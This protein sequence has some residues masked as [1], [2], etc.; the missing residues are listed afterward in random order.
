MLAVVLVALLLLSGVVYAAQPKRES[1]PQLATLYGSFDLS[2]SEKV[3]AI[4]ELQAPSIVEAKH[5]GRRQTPAKL[6]NERN[7]VIRELRK[8]TEAVVLREYFQVFSGMAIKLPANAIPKLLAIPGVQAVYP[9]VVYTANPFEAISIEPE[10]YF[11]EMLDSAPWIGADEA[12]AAGLTGKGITVAIIDTG[13]DYTHPDLAHA[14]GAYKGWDFVDNDADPQEGPGQNHGTH[15]AGTVAANGLIRGVAPGV[16]LLAYR[17]LG[18]RGGTT[19]DVVAGIERAVLD[20]ANI[21]NLSLGNTLNSPDWATSIALDWAMAEGVVAVTSNGNSGPANWTVGSPAASR[22]AISV[23]ASQL[24]Y[25]VYQASIFTSEGV[26]YPSARVMGFND[27]WELLALHGNQFEMVDVG[28]GHPEDF[29]G[30]DLE[31]KIALI[32]RGGFPFFD[33]A[34]NAYRAGAVGA[35]IYNN[36]PGDLNFFIPGMVIPTIQLSYADGR[37]ILAE[38]AS[39]NNM[40]TFDI[41]L[42]FTMPETVANFS[43]RGPAAATWMI[44]PDVVAPGVDII[45]TV[46]GGYASFQGTSMASPHVAGAAAILLQANPGWTVEQVKSALMNT[47]EVLINPV[48]G[49][50]YPHNTQGAGSIRIPA[51]LATETLILPG[52]HSFGVFAKEEGT[53]SERQH[54]II[55]NLS[56]VRKRYTV[57]VQFAN[58]IRVNVSNNLNVGA[59]KSQQVNMNVRVEAGKMAPGYYEGVILVSDGSNTFRVPAILFVGEPDYPRITHGGIVREADLAIFW[60]F[61]PGGADYVEAWIFSDTPW[62]YVGY[63]TLGANL[64]P[65]YHEFELPW[66]ATWAGLPGGLYHAFIWAEK[67]G[68]GNFIYG[69]SFAID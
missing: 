54:F 49:G 53:Q 11:P 1:I 32:S 66:D 38:M 45:S 40:V 56:R 58:G 15:V 62:S 50:P 28:L 34:I 31:G 22:Q 67:A 60:V 3:T 4:V 17:V 35:I 6:Q 41:R 10:A 37:T 46:P 13:V 48:T 44:K 39:G 69:G 9:N 36:V 55:Q 5:S 29:V 21:M 7:A 63:L 57:D 30:K 51:A 23:G 25:N 68:V 20:G 59:G 27:D 65:G 47:A 42:D 64:A 33:K 19:A 24:P 52:S 18:P 26:T 14:F 2:S 12:W 8:H 61:L 16:R 43:S